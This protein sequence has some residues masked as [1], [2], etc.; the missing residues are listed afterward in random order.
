MSYCV[1][2]DMSQEMLNLAQQKYQVEHSD[3]SIRADFT[4]MDAR[5]LAFADRSV[6]AVL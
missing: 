2:V 3:R 4:R 6:C 1:G 5:S